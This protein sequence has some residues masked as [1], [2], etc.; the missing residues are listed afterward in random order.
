MDYIQVELRRLR[1]TAVL[2]HQF[3]SDL[4]FQWATRS[5]PVGANLL[6]A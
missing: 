4:H 2:Y 6:L 1:L 5:K 3:L